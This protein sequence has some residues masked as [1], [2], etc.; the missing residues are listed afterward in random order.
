MLTTS[1]ACSLGQCE[2]ANAKLKPC[3]IHSSSQSQQQASPSEAFLCVIKP[4]SCTGFHNPTYFQMV[5]WNW[6]PEPLWYRLWL[7]CSTHI[8][9]LPAKKRAIIQ[10]L[11]I[12]YIAYIHREYG[13][14]QVIQEQPHICTLK[15]FGDTVD[16]RRIFQGGS[17]G[18]FVIPRPGYKVVIFLWCSLYFVGVLMTFFSADGPTED[19]TVM[20]CDS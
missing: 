18:L 14:V 13:P 10:I 17:S 8:Q 7:F 5:R 3:D 15:M 20:L 19:Q 2:H 9:D 12:F 16:S 4:E 11:L 6:I 1:R